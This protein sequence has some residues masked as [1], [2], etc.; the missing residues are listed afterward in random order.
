MS[1]I[2]AVRNDLTKILLVACDQAYSGIGRP[3]SADGARLAP[4]GDTGPKGNKYIP[5]PE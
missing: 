2:T 3:E 1:A 4:F 5:D